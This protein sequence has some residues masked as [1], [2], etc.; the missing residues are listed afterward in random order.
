MHS[1]HLIRQQTLARPEK[2]HVKSQSSMP[3]H[4]AKFDGT[5]SCTANASVDQVHL[6]RVAGARKPRGTARHPETHHVAWVEASQDDVVL[7]G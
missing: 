2:K 7:F 5:P 1:N 6:E 3:A 4:K